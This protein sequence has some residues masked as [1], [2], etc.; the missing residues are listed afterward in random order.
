VAR[1]TSAAR[2]VELTRPHIEFASSSGAGPRER[3]ARHV[4]RDG[5]DDDDGDDSIDSIDVDDVARTA[6]AARDA[7]RRDGER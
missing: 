2:S 5:D 4:A 6:A 1:S 7:A 3:D